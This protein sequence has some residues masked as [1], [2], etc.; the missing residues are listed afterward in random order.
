MRYKNIV[1]G[2]F[3]ERPNRFIAHVEIHGK[4]QVVHVKNT[5]RCKELL[6]PGATVYLEK[7]CNSQRSTAYDLIA[8][9]K[10]TRLI[11]MDSQI[12]N[13]V[14]E[15]WLKQGT[16]FEDLVLLRPETKYGN[17]RFDF[18]AQTKKYHNADI[19]LHAHSFCMK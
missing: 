12:P 4:E 8:V 13:R 19:S 3:L 5:G 1:Q 6:V 15:E 14:L 9:E 11:N 16:F 18:Y 2:T 17:S 7:S 10:G